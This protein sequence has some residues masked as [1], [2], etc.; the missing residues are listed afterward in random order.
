[1]MTYVENK[2]IKS[3]AEAKKEE[4]SLENYEE[5]NDPYSVFGFGIVAYFSTMRILILAFTICS[6]VW[7]PT[8]Y[9]Y[10]QGNGLSNMTGSNFL[11][12]FSLGN[13]G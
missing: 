1:M 3:K 6:L 13:L 10:Q 9:K 8:I 11:N 4:V 2:K 7:M 12:M 5:V